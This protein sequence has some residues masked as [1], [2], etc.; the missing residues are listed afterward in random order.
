MSDTQPTPELLA[1]RNR[2][3][4]L[5]GEILTLISERAQC[6]QQVAEI[7]VA[8]VLAQ[9]KETGESPEPVFLPT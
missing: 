6:A 5:D 7:K 4:A 8:E 3:D 2:I 9:A 1:I